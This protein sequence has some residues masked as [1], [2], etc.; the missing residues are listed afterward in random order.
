[1]I[2]GLTQWVKDLVLPL[3]CGICHRRGLDLM[4]LQLWHR[5]AA[6]ALT[7]PLVWEPL[8]AMCV[9]L[10]SGQKKTPNI[11]YVIQFVYFY[12]WD[13]AYSGSSK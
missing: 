2:P 12:L 3:S 8:Y 13:V 9:A 5:L 6:V 11:L 4:L 7:G 1:M 10:K